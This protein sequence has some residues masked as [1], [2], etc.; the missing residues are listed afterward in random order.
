[1]RSSTVLRVILILAA[2]Q[3]ML[4]TRASAQIPGTDA[5]IIVQGKF[6]GERLFTLPGDTS[7]P[8]DLNLDTRASGRL[9]IAV[10]QQTQFVGRIRGESTRAVVVALAN[11]SPL[12]QSL[13]TAVMANLTAFNAVDVGKGAQPDFAKAVDDL[14]AAASA[15]QFAQGDVNNDVQLGTITPETGDKL[16]TMI[17][18]SAA[19]V[20]DTLG[21]I[22]SAPAGH[23]NAKRVLAA[24]RNA[25]VATRATVAAAIKAKA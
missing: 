6:V 9:V 4:P 15:L 17:Q 22:G 11:A 7:V 5:F 12:W 23:P 21:L 19:R 1:V 2:L 3:G 20:D 24:I 10:Q 14:N 18:R 13:S 8:A 25:Q 16:Q